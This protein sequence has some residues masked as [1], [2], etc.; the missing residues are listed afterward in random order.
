MTNE[1]RVVPHKRA[2]RRRLS[3]RHS[4]FSFLLLLHHP[5]SAGESRRE[6]FTAHLDADQIAVPQFVQDENCDGLQINGCSLLRA[7]SKVPLYISNQLA[8][9][10]LNVTGATSVQHTRRRGISQHVDLRCCINRSCIDRRCHVSR[11]SQRIGSG[12][13]DP[14]L[15]LR[16]TGR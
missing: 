5:P 1:A 4:I 2:Q 11:R 16:R 14:R 12:L 3:Q 13:Y 10:S 15:R 8:Q 6:V 7:I 9:S